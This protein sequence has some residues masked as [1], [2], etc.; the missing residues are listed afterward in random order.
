MNQEEEQGDSPSIQTP[1]IIKH[2]NG[3]SDRIGEK[4][5]ACINN[6]S[7]AAAPTKK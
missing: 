6:M 4:P 2:G 5:D 3:V 1:A 7:A